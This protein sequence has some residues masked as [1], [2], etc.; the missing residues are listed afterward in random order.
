MKQLAF[1]LSFAFAAQPTEACTASNA[2]E[3]VSTR[4]K[5]HTREETYVCDSGW[6]LIRVCS[7][8]V[9]EHS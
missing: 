7:D 8:G 6:Q 5:A 2:G 3:I 1:I 9:C 4:N